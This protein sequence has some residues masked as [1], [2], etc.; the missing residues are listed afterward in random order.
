MP[1]LI[2]AACLISP[3]LFENWDWRDLAALALLAYSL[4]FLADR[5]FTKAG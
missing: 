3:L 5:M 1:R 2:I 4:N